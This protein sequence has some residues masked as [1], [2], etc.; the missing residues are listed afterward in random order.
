MS[1][2][3]RAAAGLDFG[4][5][6]DTGGGGWLN[7]DITFFIDRPSNGFFDAS[8]GFDASLGL[9]VSS[10][11]FGFGNVVVADGVVV[12]DAALYL[13]LLPVAVLP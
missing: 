4:N 5:T 11:G 10:A 9:A 3:A 6:F 13:L 7:P 8:C 12:L 2:P 1:T